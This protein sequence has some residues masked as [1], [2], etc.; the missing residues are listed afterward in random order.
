MALYDGEILYLDHQLQR[1]FLE[2][3]R[4]NL[5][6]DALI[7]VTSDHGEEFLDHGNWAHGPE[8]YEELVRIPLLFKLPRGEGGGRRVDQQV[9]LLDVAPTI[10]D[11]LDLPVPDSFQG[12]SLLAE[13]QGNKSKST[14]IVWLEVGS[15]SSSTTPYQ[16]SLRQG[17][18]GRKIIFKKGTHPTEIYDLAQDPRESRNL[19]EGEGEALE[20]MQRQ[21]A[22]FF[23]LIG[24]QQDTSNSLPA[25]LAPEDVEQLRALGYVR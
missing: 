10:L 21:L 20:E 7:V 19:S 25:D 17:A 18:A 6:D 3:K 8:L 11:L 14:S 22:E 15:E 5:F 9:S 4:L 23:A 16:V 1:F 12:R 24:E 13:L 2:M